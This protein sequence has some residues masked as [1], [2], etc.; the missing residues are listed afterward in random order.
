MYNDGTCPSTTA[1][2]GI[3]TR[4]S[5]PDAYGMLLGTSLICSFL[6]IGMS[7]ISPRILKKIFPPMVTGGSSVSCLFSVFE[8][9]Y[10]A[11][12]CHFDDRGIPHRR[13]WYPELGRRLQRLRFSSRVWNLRSV[14]NHIRQTSTTVRMILAYNVKSL[15]CLQMGLS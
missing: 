5:C 14:S 7:F 9:L 8:G 11:R 6:E 4:G 1:E 10:L 15:T 2:D 13:L 3:V 12:Y